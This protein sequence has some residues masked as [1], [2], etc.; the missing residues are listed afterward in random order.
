MLPKAQVQTAVFYLSAANGRRRPAAR[1]TTAK[2]KRLERTSLTILT[3]QTARQRRAPGDWEH[4]QLCP[5]TRSSPEGDVKVRPVMGTSRV[6]VQEKDP[7]ASRRSL[8]TQQ[9]EACEQHGIPDV[10]P[11]PCGARETRDSA[12]CPQ[13]REHK[14]STCPS[15]SVHHTHL[16]FP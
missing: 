7:E 15:R 2:A 11:S 10:D 14:L 6:W 4:N 3:N 5:A 9:C 16:S 8:R 1:V 13:C 12:S